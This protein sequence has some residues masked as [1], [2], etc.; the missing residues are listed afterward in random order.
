MKRLIVFLLI[1]LTFAGIYNFSTIRHSVSG[2]FGDISYQKED[3]LRAEKYYRTILD[4]A[5]GDTL[6]RAD[7]LYNLG[8][9]L[10]KLGEKEKDEKKIKLWKESIGSYTQ[11]LSLRLD[12]QTEENLA[13]VQEKLKNAEKEQEQKKQEEQ[14]KKDEQQKKDE[15]KKTG[16]GSDT[17]DNIG[18]NPSVRPENK[19]NTETGNTKNKTQSGQNWSNGGSYNSIG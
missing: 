12:T 3:L 9:T 15:E 8:N 2:L 14:K 13:F 1:L 18:A 10:Y 19:D 5:S 6:L 4:T 17:K 16:S 11:S 7:T